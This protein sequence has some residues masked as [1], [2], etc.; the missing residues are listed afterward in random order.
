[1]PSQPASEREEGGDLEKICGQKCIVC[2]KGE[3]STSD[4]DF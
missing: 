2:R 4:L 1:M 3:A